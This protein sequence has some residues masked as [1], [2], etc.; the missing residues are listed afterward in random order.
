VLAVPKKERPVPSYLNVRCYRYGGDTLKTVNTPAE[1]D[2]VRIGMPG[3][4]AGVNIETANGDGLAR[5]WWLVDAFEA[6]HRR[7]FADGRRD[8]IEHVRGVFASPPARGV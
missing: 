1:A 2:V 4:S 7:A 8:V 5:F 6:V 3:L